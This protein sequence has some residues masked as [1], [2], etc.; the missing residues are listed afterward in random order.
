MKLQH[1]ITCMVAGAMAL[2]VLATGVAQ[3]MA[4]QALSSYRADMDANA[5]QLRAVADMRSGFQTQVQEWKN[6]LLRGRDPAQLD[7]YWASFQKHEAEVAQRAQALVDSLPAGPLREQAQRFGQAHATMGVGYRQGLEAYRNAGGDHSAGDK[8]V[9]GMDREPTAQLGQLL[10]A[11]EAAGQAAAVAVDERT[12]RARNLQFALEGLALVAAIVGTQLFTRRQLAPLLQAR[13]VARRVADGDLGTPITPRGNDEIAELNAA[14]RDMQQALAR[15]VHHVRQGAESVATA[16]AQIA[17]GNQD[18]SGRTERQA[19][20][21]QQTASTM[22]QL[23]ATAR[24]TADSAQQAAQLA[25]GASGIAV[26]GGEVV[27]QVVDTMRGIQDSSRRIADIIGVID[28]IAF[29][30]NILALNAAVEAARAGEQGR[31][32]AVVA[33]EV[34]SLA[35]RSAEAAREIKGL[36]TASVERV[37]AGTALVD[38]A[39]STMQEIVAAV[40]RV[41]DIIGEI[42]AAGRE[43]S[44]GVAQVGQAV[45]RMDQGTQQ[46]AALVEQ[47]AAA[48]DSLRQQA[49]QLVQAVGVFRL[50]QG[51][52]RSL[53]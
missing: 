12:S 45:T 1:R 34:R 6:T 13:D 26:Q 40:Q 30:T 36:I 21:L 2:L 24:H 19:G 8:A 47:S 39:G 29:Q 32:F 46:N 33:G 9:K 22:E 50:A 44:A 15:T 10:T 25:Q 3:G 37:D 52:G 53:I 16:S 51:G 42:S 43:Q 20:E 14:L 48:A 5:A 28:G 11:V 31:G 4:G 35:Q 18:L 7:K 17:Q 41:S 27:G 38:R 23:G 49:D